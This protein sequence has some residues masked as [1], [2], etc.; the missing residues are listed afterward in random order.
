MKNYVVGFITDG[1][2]VLLIKKNRPDF[3]KGLYNGV[4]GLILENETP[5]DAI[6]RK[7]KS[8]TGLEINDWIKLD[9][10]PYPETET[11]LHLFQATVSKKF[12]KHYRT[13]TDE[14]VR[15][16]K[17]EEL[18]FNIFPDVSYICK[19]RLI[20]QKEQKALYQFSYLDEFGNGL[21]NY[22]YTT[23]TNIRKMAKELFEK[24]KLK[25]STKKDETMY[26]NETE[27]FSFDEESCT[28][29]IIKEVGF[30]LKHYIDYKKISDSNKNKSVIYELFENQ[31][32]CK[33]SVSIY[34][35]LSKGLKKLKEFSLDA[36]RGLSLATEDEEGN[37]IRNGKLTKDKRGNYY[38]NYYYWHK[39]SYEYDEWDVTKTGFTLEPI[40]IIEL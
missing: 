19:R 7:T 13:T 9:T 40:K 29:Y 4:G 2:R 20:K 3:Q 27:L 21:K 32:I 22:F 30:T 26:S 25:A 36:S 34:F 39:I 8:E 38:C 24:E 18:P 31:Y 16:F 28:G 23:E 6:I 10:F 15:L 14:I 5:L 35:S 11:T 1:K 33:S 12:I 17:I 37:S